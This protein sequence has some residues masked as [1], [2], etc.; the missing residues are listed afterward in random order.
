MSSGQDAAEKTK[1]GIKEL[2]NMAESIRKNVNSF[3]D[4]LIGSKSGTHS[5]TADGSHT[6]PTA[7]ALSSTSGHHPATGR[8]EVHGGG[9]IAS[10]HTSSARTAGADTL[11][12][13]QGSGGILGNENSTPDA[14]AV[15]TAGAG[16]MSTSGVGPQTSNLTR[17]DGKLAEGADQ[18]GRQ[19]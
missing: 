18:L 4:D 11:G 15:N 5:N 1:G 13:K 16:N 9:V 3:A 2:G 12:H 14:D 6:T 17:S 7:D 8:D 19:Y 10:E